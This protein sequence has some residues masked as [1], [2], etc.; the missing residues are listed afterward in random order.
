MQAYEA[1]KRLKADRKEFL[2]Q[3]GLKSHMSKIPADLEAELFGEEK[4]IQT[5]PEPTAGTDTTEATT[6][7]VDSA[8]TLVAECPYT[9]EQVRKNIR[10]LG[11]K[12]RAWQWRHIL[13]G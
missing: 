1:I 4:K 5:E 6:I 7:T 2:E 9:K 3:Y 13:D 12:S 8:E 11:C 10:L